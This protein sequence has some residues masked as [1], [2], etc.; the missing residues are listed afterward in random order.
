MKNLKGLI[1][2]A[3]AFIVSPVFSSEYQLNSYQLKN[4]LTVI[5]NEDHSQTKVYGTVAVR[6]GAVNDP[7]DA[8]GLAHYLEHV[9]FN[10][11]TNVG[12]INWE[13]EKVHY[14]N[15]IDLFEKLRTTE[16]DDERNTIIDQINKESIAEGKYF[17][18][19][20]FVLLLESIGTSGINAA[21]GY[22]YTFF[23]S[24]F[25]PS[26]SAAWLEIYANEFTNS[27]FRNFQAELET[28]YEEYNMGSENPMGNFFDTALKNM[29]EGSPYG[30]D[31]LGYSK[32][33]KSPSL[34]KLIEFY[35]TWYVPS[36][37]A[38][39]LV[40]DFDSEKIKGEIEATFGKWEARPL[41]KELNVEKVAL[42]KKTKIR[43]KETP[44][45]IGLWGFNAPYTTDNDVVKMQLLN[46]ILSNNASIGLLDQL[47]TDGDVMSIGSFYLPMK[48][49]SIF[50]IQAIPNFDMAQM[51]QLSPSEIDDLIFD[52]IEEIKKGKI[53][54]KL[55]SSVRDN[56]IRNFSVML[57]DF[58]GRT[59]YIIEY[60]TAGRD[61]N[62]I[63]TYI[64]ELNKVT[65]DDIVKI[66]NQYLNNTYLELTSSRGEIKLEEIKKPEIEPVLQTVEAPSEFA[67]YMADKMT[68]PL[69]NINYIDFN[70]DIQ[71]T[72]IADKVKLYYK[73]NTQNDI[74]NL[75]ISYKAGTEKIPTLDLA[76]QLMNNAGIRGN[77]KPHE[78]KKK[79]GELGC[80]Y[81]F[82]AGSN[83]LNVSISGR[84][85]NLEE[86]CK[87]ISMI[88]LMP[89]LD[90]KQYNSLIG[91]EM[92]SRNI[93]KNDFQSISTA[94]SSYIIYGENSPYI[95]RLSWN[96]LSLVN[97]NSLTSDF[98]KATKYEATVHYVGNT[99]FEEAKSRLLN[100]LAFASG[101]LDAV[102][103]Y[104]RPINQAT[105]STIYFINKPGTRQS[106]ITI[107][108]PANESFKISDDAS[109]NAFSKYFGEG[110]G[111][112]FFQEIREF[113]SMAYSASASVYTP[114]IENKPAFLV[115]RVATQGDKTNDAMTVI[116]D[117]LQNMP[118]K[119]NKAESVRSNLMYGSIISRPS[120]RYLTQYIESWER[121]GYTED[122][123]KMN[124]EGYQKAHMD[125]IN[126][127][128]TSNI[129]GKPISV[130]VVGDKKKI[131][132]KAFEKLGN[133]QYLNS[134]KLFNE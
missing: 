114:Y 56:Y 75:L 39:I 36:N 24:L 23:H 7:E 126:S 12:T 101:R 72:N 63:N 100:S 25:P 103:F 30:K 67:S 108:V 37:M 125:Y 80:T 27:V 111:N 49:A 45:N 17:Q 77:Y 128:F 134:S 105:E 104:Q 107:M 33:L 123:T 48:S 9:L 92:N 28:V 51:R 124:Q 52:K 81:S 82:S 8:T 115:G 90:I 102:E 29:W 55:L 121:L 129:K 6:A 109:I 122:P 14:N 83:N 78:L 95:K 62:L 119:T 58:G 89:D 46:E 34:K 74:F 113:R 59:Q 38:L 96:D 42:K 10:G 1:A 60:F 32:D 71:R 61:V 130:V 3:L 21:T 64:D 53:D 110:L 127:Y 16:D 120:D 88:T 20:E 35:Q 18:T 5:L 40:G 70:A 84:E 93:Q 54:E 43:I 11:T 131:D 50:A 4:G 112:I 22:D 68:P 13:E 19:K 133:Y 117:L 98:M 66:A 31:V 41:G 94:A 57:E 85:K 91:M 15:I 69:G 26:Q 44:Y 116:F 97:I 73:Q 99:P 76:A 79:M 86:A 2:F 132:T 106:N 118:Q 87:L 65:V 47:Q